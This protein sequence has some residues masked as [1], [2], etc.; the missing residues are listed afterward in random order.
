MKT[1][2]FQFTAFSALLVLL[3][4]ASCSND[5]DTAS[6]LPD[7]IEESGEQGSE[8]ENEETPLDTDN[9]GIP[10]SEDDDVD[11]DGLIELSSVDALNE[12]RYSLENSG[13]SYRGVAK[14]QIIGFELTQDLD[15]QDPGHYD[16]PTLLE[17]YTTGKGWEPIGISNYSFGEEEDMST[18]FGG[19]FEGNGFTIKNLFISR[20]EDSQIGFLGA[21]NDD[22]IIRN[23]NLELISVNGN[24]IVGGLV[25]LGRGLI[26]NCTVNGSINSE[27]GEI[28][29][30]TGVYEGGTIKECNTSGTVTAENNFNAGGLFGRLVIDPFTENNAAIKSCYSSANVVG[31]DRV[32]GLIGSF[33]LGDAINAFITVDN[34]FAIGSVTGELNVGGLIGFTGGTITSCYA[35]GEVT[36]TRQGFG[37][38]AGGLVGQSLGALINSCYATG[39]VRAVNQIDC[40]G[41]L[42]G[43]IHSTNVTTSYS[44]GSVE[45]N[46]AQIGGLTGRCPAGSEPTINNTNYWDA[47]TS[48]LPFSRGEA[49][50]LTTVE[51]QTPTSNTGI[52]ATWDP[53]IWDFGTST[54]YPVLLDMPN[55]IEP[56]R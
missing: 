20:P 14:N 19:I 48:G 28:G 41:G 27:L 38:N 32:G 6:E 16:D 29:L 22:S 2:L 3:F 47:E 43:Y 25:G 10:D 17:E 39:N 33:N 9:D 8:E 23:L 31:R 1:V 50:G 12:M 52:Y 49:Q 15:F 56:Q 46:L 35:T 34:C 42:I 26:D 45:G 37:G 5:A 13:K 54:Q 51:L 24:T 11:G 18:R 30:L 21:C 44:I 40:M 4:L 36:A 7:P 53:A 55:G